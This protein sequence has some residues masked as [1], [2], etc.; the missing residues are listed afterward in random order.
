M[1]AAILAAEEVV[2]T[3]EV[4]V[5]HAAEAGHTALTAA[6]RALAEAQRAVEDLYNRWQELEG[7]RGP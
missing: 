3:C 5:E 7:R 6:C 2:A 1:E 4:E